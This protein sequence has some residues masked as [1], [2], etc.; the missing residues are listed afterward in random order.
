MLRRQGM[1]YHSVDRWVGDRKYG[2]KRYGGKMGNN[3]LMRA[4]ERE[5]GVGAGS[6]PFTIRTAHKPRGSVYE[7]CSILNECM[8]HNG[9]YIDPR[10]KQL[11]K[12]LQHFTFKDDEN[13]HAID[14]LRYGAIELITRRLYAPSKLKMY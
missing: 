13:K 7:G 2:G 9:F 3:R 4:L 11:I 10:C 14:A 5:I 8:I 1:N 6:L 12:S